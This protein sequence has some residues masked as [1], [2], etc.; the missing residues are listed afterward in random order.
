[1]KK[2]LCIYEMLYFSRFSYAVVKVLLK[3]TECPLEH[4][5]S[6]ASYQPKINSG[7]IGS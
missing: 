2:L 3:Q 6:P 1:M 7:V 4:S 5:V